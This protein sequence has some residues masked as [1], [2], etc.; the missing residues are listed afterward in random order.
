MPFFNLNRPRV[1]NNS[2]KYYMSLYTV[3]SVI[4]FIGLLV[5]LQ[6][7]HGGIRGDD[8]IKPPQLRQFYQVCHW[9]SWANSADK[10]SVI[11][12]KFIFLNFLLAIQLRCLSWAFQWTF[13]NPPMR[14]VELEFVYEKLWLQLT[15][16]ILGY[17]SVGG[18]LPGGKSHETV[19]PYH[20]MNEF[21]ILFFVGLIGLRLFSEVL[22]LRMDFLGM[23]SNNPEASRSSD[24]D[25][26]QAERYSSPRSRITSLL[27]FALFPA[28]AL[29]ISGLR[30]S[31]QVFVENPS[32]GIH[33]LLAFEYLCLVVDLFMDGFVGGFLV[34]YFGSSE[35]STTNDL[36]I[37]ISSHKLKAFS[38]LIRDIFKFMA[39][40]SFI[41]Y[42]IGVRRSMPLHTLHRVWVVGRGV[43]V[44]FAD[45]WR[46]WKAWRLVKWLQLEDIRGIDGGAS[47]G[48]GMVDADDVCI[49]CREEFCPIPEDDNTKEVNE[50]RNSSFHSRKFR[51]LCQLP[52][53][54][55]FHADCVS[56]W[57]DR[58]SKCPTCRRDVS[59]E[60]PRNEANNQINPVNM[61]RPNALNGGNPPDNRVNRPSSSDSRNTEA[62]N[63]N[64]DS[65]SSTNE[66]N[67]S[68]ASPT[69]PIVLSDGTIDFGTKRLVPLS[70]YADDLTGVSGKSSIP[71]QSGNSAEARSGSNQPLESRIEEIKALKKSID[72]ILRRA[73]EL[74]VD[75]DARNSEI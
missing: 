42:L 73:D 22:V 67:R 69:N 40:L 72:E 17:S 27:F 34:H 18:S 14:V 41:A 6:I 26:V 13:T 16:L 15:E 62:P 28:I 21:N 29:S 65:S 51:K 31:Y 36:P 10:N 60:N 7:N 3:A 58:Q 50:E 59:E 2:T 56:G 53:G 61:D 57:L 37:G 19:S 54:H 48:S 55:I 23:M 52:C 39:H 5:G 66:Q 24:N 49:I 70:K 44:R 33:L 25:G 75:R 43:V 8:I 45:G 68:S 71:E 12:S 1:E 63:R 38:E 9:L 11:P 4:G 47:E 35:N 32:L 64:T 74:G 46:G 30:F 20:L